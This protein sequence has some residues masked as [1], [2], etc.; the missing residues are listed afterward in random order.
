MDNQLEKINTVIYDT[1]KEASKVVASKIADLI[2]SKAQ[3][4]KMCVL[5]L[6]TGST[7]TSV[8]AELIRLHQEEGLSFKKCRHFQP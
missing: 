2:K 4:G 5:G 8:Y 7:P 6:A 3:K 1:S